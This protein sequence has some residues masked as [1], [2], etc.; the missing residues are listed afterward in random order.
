MGNENVD[1][2][3]NMPNPDLLLDESYD[4]APSEIRD[5]FRQT[6][7]DEDDQASS[8]FN[9]YNMDDEGEDDNY[10]DEA[11]GDNMDQEVNDSRRLTVG[12]FMHRPEVAVVG[13]NN[14]MPLGW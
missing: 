1:Q 12:E 11:S 5:Q 14:N 4:E 6:V 3:I 13:H 8:A 10:G 7:L 9:G 2:E